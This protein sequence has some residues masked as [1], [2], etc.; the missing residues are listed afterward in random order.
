[1]ASIS[2]DIFMDKLE[3]PDVF[4]KNN[5]VIAD[6][7]VHYFES[8]LFAKKTKIQLNANLISFLLDGTKE[9]YHNNQS[10][11]ISND[12]FVLA[13]SG[14]CLMTETLSVH[15][16]YASLLFFFDNKIIADFK[17]KYDVPFTINTENTAYSGPFVVLPYDH[18]IKN[19]VSSLSSLLQSQGAVQANFLQLKLEEILLYLTQKYGASILTFFE[20]TPK[21]KS[22]KKLQAIVEGNIF[23]KLTLDELAF[24]CHMSLSTF[25]RE[26]IKI[27]KTSPS[28]W[29]Q[30]R[31]LEK[32]A[33]LLI[34]ENERPSDIYLSVGYESL[35]SFTQ[36][37]KQKFG[38]T[39]KK[40][41]L[42]FV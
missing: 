4:V 26:F 3:L 14:N 32:S 40:Y 33:Q 12:Q 17:K 5:N 16:K 38:K 39:P 20:V 27:Y 10:Q 19:F 42:Q 22:N 31:R 2:I 8:D 7:V 34:Q 23:S 21:L 25:K 9:L 13:K 30:D 37:F 24:L 18:F 29:F 28:K 15:K 41:Q 35:S 36:S 11:I 6:V 1:M